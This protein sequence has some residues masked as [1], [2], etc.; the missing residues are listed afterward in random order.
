MK[1]DSSSA[2][3]R[4]RGENKRTRGKKCH[5]EK[6]KNEDEDE[7]WMHTSSP[8]IKEVMEK[9]ITHV[10]R[11]AD[12]RKR[13]ERKRAN[14]EEKRKKIGRI[15]ETTQKRRELG[16]GDKFIVWERQKLYCFFFSK[17]C[18]K[19]YTNRVSLAS[20]EWRVKSEI[21]FF[22]ASDNTST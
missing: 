15:W 3:R 8:Y 21:S 9:I 6:K 11:T 4:E 19:K 16:G 13:R 1:W 22:V 10:I 20:L 5:W 17:Y 12:G 2:R 14:R 7:K 18:Y